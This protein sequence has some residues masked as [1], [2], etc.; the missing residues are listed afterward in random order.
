MSTARIPPLIEQAMGIGGFK[1]AVAGP[2]ALSTIAQEDL[3]AVPPE[4]MSQFVGAASWDVNDPRQP[5][6]T[7]LVRAAESAAQVVQDTRKE[8]LAVHGGLGQIQAGIRSILDLI[9]RLPRGGGNVEAHEQT[10]RYL[11]TLLERLRTVVPEEQQR[12]T[13][14]QDY[15]NL[16]DELKTAEEKLQ[17]ELGQG[18]RKSTGGR[19]KR[20]RKRGGFMYSP[21]ARKASVARLKSRKALGRTYRRKRHKDTVRRRRKE[22]RRRQRKRKIRRRRRGGRTRSRRGGRTIRRRR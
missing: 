7:A 5:L 19:R 2:P 21:A 20:R 9:N 3:F 4:Q 6:A 10:I 13:R 12:A 18:G 14:T 11:M 15:K 16:L 17:E 22:T 1:V 8:A